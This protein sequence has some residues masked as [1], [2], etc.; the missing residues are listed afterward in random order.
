ML[1]QHNN[2][3]HPLILSMLWDFQHVSW[4]REFHMKNRQEQ[5]EFHRHI[6]AIIACVCV[7]HT[8]GMVSDFQQQF[9]TL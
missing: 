4:P 2:N 7:N 9:H 1:E 6:K 8:L 5:Q 3:N